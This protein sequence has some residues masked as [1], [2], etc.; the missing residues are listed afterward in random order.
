M[1]P[2]Y[3]ITNEELI[4][5]KHRRIAQDVGNPSYTELWLTVD[6]KRIFKLFSADEAIKY[7][8]AADIQNDI[9]TLLALSNSRVS[10]DARF[11][12]PD[13]IYEQQSEIIGYSMPNIR[14]ISLSQA[15][16]L[17]MSEFRGIVQQIYADVLMVNQNVGFSFADLHED[18]I[19]LGADGCVYHI[20][21]D[22]WYCGDGIGRRSRYLTFQKE[23]LAS[24]SSK[25][26]I[27]R[28]G[29]IIPNLN[30]DMLCLMHM[31]LNHLL[32]ADFYF[33]EMVEDEQER[34]LQYITKH[35]DDIDVDRI[36]E[37]FFSDD[38]ISFNERTILALPNDIRSFSYNEFVKRTSKFKNNSDAE[39]YLRQNEL[40]LK[41]L[42][43]DRTVLQS[44]DGTGH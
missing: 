26:G 38:V 32:Q 18:N 11:V 13:M 3:E 12:L 31:I 36:Y 41:K 20:D 43:P 15:K 25:Y 37:S 5:Y 22:G 16:S 39:E 44:T 28:S 9:S 2:I 35:C 21:L 23:K 30:T 40:R 14:G 10:F 6:G 33:A 8:C 24:Y 4:L 27:D 17:N 1:I 34:Y 19:I 42:F 7:A 29:N